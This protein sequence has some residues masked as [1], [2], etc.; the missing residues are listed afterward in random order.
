MEQTGAKATSGQPQIHYKH[1]TLEV[2]T[3]LLGELIVRDTVSGVG[4]RV[5]PFHH[6]EIKFT[7]NGRFEL[8]VAN[9]TIECR[10]RR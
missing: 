8:V 4:I 2:S 3:N 10:V 5:S 6:G 9:N 1:G 7:A